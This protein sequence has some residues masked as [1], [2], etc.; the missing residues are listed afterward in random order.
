MGAG[1]RA[2]RAALCRGRRAAARRTRRASSCRSSSRATSPSAAKRAPSAPPNRPPRRPSSTAG[3]T[4]ERDPL[5]LRRADRRA[6]RRQVDAAQRARR[7]EGLDRLAQGADDARDRAR[8][9]SSRARRRSS[10]ST[11][12][13]CSR[14]S[15]GS[16]AR[17]SP[18]A[19]GAAADADALALLIDARQE[20]AA[21]G[22]GRRRDG[23]GLERGDAD[24]PRRR[25]SD[26]RRRKSSS[27]TRSISSTA[28]RCWRSPRG[29]TRRCRSRETFMISAATGDGL[30][31]LQARPRRDDAAG[32][33]ALSRKTRSPTRRCARSPPRSPARSCSSAC[34]TNC[35][36][37]RRSRPNRWK[38]LPDGSARIEQTIYV[39]RD[40]HKKI[41]IG[42]GGR[43]HQVDR[44]GGA[45]GDRRGQRGHGAS[46]PV[47]EGAREL[48]RRSRALPRDGARVPEELTFA[49]ARNRGRSR[50]RLGRR[51]ARRGRVSGTVANPEGSG[52]PWRLSGDRRRSRRSA[53]A[54]G[55]TGR[56]TARFGRLPGGGRGL[57]GPDRARRRRFRARRRRAV[58]RRL[59]D[60]RAAL[61]RAAADADLHPRFQ[62]SPGGRSLSLSA[63]D[64]RARGLDDRRRLA[65]RKSSDASRSWSH[66]SPP[67]PLATMLAA[68]ARDWTQLLALRALTGLALVGPAGG[69]DG[70]SLRRNG[71]QGDRPRDGALYRRQHAR[72]HVRTPRRRR[73]S[74]I[75]GT[76]A[77]RSPR[78]GAIGLAGRGA[79]LFA[80]PRSRTLRA[81][82]PGSRRAPGLR[83]PAISPIPACGCC[84]PLGFLVMGALRLHL[85]LHR[86]PARRR[87]RS[88]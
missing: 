84:S 30:D 18:S 2:R 5:R 34:T 21:A 56:G 7:R 19:W 88:R 24:D 82:A 37:R 80:L 31:R 54:R 22:Q 42:E 71:R 23:R 60:I 53:K 78:S 72:R 16:T 1:A 29:S 3:A 66:R 87:R 58:L 68:L 25:C 83:S 46:L 69:R 75:S 79:S 61:Q 13:A 36:I 77:P 86:L 41:V 57:P 51:E 45:Q 27:S 59:L 47:R 64:R 70:L 43:T 73:S 11:R 81:G 40:S 10:S 52:R 4:H 26:N 32:A 8:R 38:D 49:S 33:L 35:P 28:P 44:L 15:A 74:P 55:R 9:S 67:R 65:S 6:Q 48:A 12:P 14:P 62:V 20:I 85:Q 63:T 76:G 50:V 39:T 17:W